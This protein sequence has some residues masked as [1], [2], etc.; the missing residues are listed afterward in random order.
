ME[1]GAPCPLA[2]PRRHGFCAYPRLRARAEGRPLP[3]RRTARSTTC[4]PDSYGARRTVCREIQGYRQPSG[5]WT[6]RDSFAIGVSRYRG[7]SITFAVTKLV[8]VAYIQMY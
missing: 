7:D 4:V 3:H 5:E 8:T 2:G 6:A 1:S